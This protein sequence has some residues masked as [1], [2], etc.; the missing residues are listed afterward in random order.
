MDVI[1]LIVFCLHIFGE[2]LAQQETCEDPGIPTNGTT[3]D[4][5]ITNSQFQKGETIRYC[6][7]EGYNLEGSSVII[8]QQ[9]QKWNA[10]IPNCVENDNENS[11]INV[12]IIVTTTIVA[13]A[14]VLCSLCCLMIVLFIIIQKKIKNR[15]I[16]SYLNLFRDR[17]KSFEEDSCHY[18]LPR[19]CE[20]SVSPIRTK[21]LTHIP[22]QHKMAP[23]YTAPFHAEETLNI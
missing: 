20:I 10:S 13:A 21:T 16:D 11:K 15:K 8:C 23:M 14:A 1:V 18:T 22:M 6:C 9:D 3:C 5:N 4:D 12:I 7:D 19:D 2:I 17:E